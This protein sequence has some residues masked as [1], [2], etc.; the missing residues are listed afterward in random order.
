MS[1]DSSIGVLSEEAERLVALRLRG[2]GSTTLV[3]SSV[4]ESS[5]AEAV[6]VV[7]VALVLADLGAIEI[8]FDCLKGHR[9]W[10]V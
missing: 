9:E 5:I 6:E 10:C 2:A 3:V 4:L 8:V 7:V 1:L